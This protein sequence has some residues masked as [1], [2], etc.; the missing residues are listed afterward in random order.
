MLPA[1]L[2][3]AGFALHA[4]ETG[5]GPSFREPVKVLLTT[6]DCDQ[7]RIKEAG[8]TQEPVSPQPGGSKSGTISPPRGYLAMSEDSF[9]CHSWQIGAIGI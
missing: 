8:A 7:K 6:K 9:G 1:T 4:Q 2:L 5:T 3:L